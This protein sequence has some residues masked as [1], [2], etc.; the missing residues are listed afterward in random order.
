MHFAQT[1]F[2]HGQTFMKT[3]CGDIEFMEVRSF[4]QLSYTSDNM[5]YT[6]YRNSLHSTQRYCLGYMFR[7]IESY[8]GH[9]PML[10]SLPD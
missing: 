10:V 5:I 3:G 7:D 1:L 9:G 4:R 8:N 2:N 6:N